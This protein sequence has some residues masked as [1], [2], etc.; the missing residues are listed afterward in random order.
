A[1]LSDICPTDLAPVTHKAPVAGFPRA[2]PSTTRDELAFL[3]LWTSPYM[4]G[5]GQSS[6]SR[7][8]RA[9]GPNR[10]SVLPPRRQ[11]RE[12]VAQPLDDLHQ[13]QEHD[14]RPEHHGSLEA[15]VPEPV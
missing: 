11:P 2:V 9:G 15:L 13:Q 3:R 12:K 8:S 7:G 1:H 10:K 6:Q 5:Q 4:A 14:D